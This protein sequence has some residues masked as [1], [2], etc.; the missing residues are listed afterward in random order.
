MKALA[1]AS[2]AAAFFAAGCSSSGS[3][4]PCSGGPTATL[5]VT[6]VDDTNE[7]INICDAM[8]TASGPTHVTFEPT[9]GT[10]S[11]SY[12]GTVIAG[13]YEITATA[14]GYETE[15]PTEITIQSGCSV[16]TSIDMTPATP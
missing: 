11:C 1:A 5:T 4:S 8:V 13:A 3:T 6:V 14:T 7:P 10:G 9:G 12:L 16:S 15:T 2:L